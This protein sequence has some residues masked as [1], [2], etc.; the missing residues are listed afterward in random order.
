MF[1][2]ESF[3]QLRPLNGLH[4]CGTEAAPGETWAETQGMIFKKC[5]A[6]QEVEI[7]RKL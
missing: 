5:A 4:L 1:A 7:H 6:D 2:M 3:L